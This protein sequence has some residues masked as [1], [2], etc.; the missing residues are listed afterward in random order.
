MSI[1]AALEAM[2]LMATE[3]VPADELA[4]A[5][6]APSAEVQGEL[7]AIARFY[8]LHGRGIQLRAVAGGWR[9]ATRE[10]L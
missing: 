1:A 9:F 2:L 5:L 7:E 3:P 10:D 6:E 8:E 4:A